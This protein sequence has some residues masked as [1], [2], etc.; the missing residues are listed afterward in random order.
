MNKDE[1]KTTIN[2]RVMQSKSDRVTLYRPYLVWS[3]LVLGFGT[4]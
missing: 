1:E 4:K 3:S 2:V